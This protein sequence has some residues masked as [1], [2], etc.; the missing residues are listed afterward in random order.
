MKG[1]FFFVAVCLM[2]VLSCKKEEPVVLNPVPYIEI[3]SV[4]PLTLVQF[5]KNVRVT[6]SYDDQDGDLG[7]FHPDSLSLAATDSRLTVPDYYHISPLT[8]HGDSLHIR[9]T[10]ALDLRSPFLLGTGTSE[11]IHYTIKV[12]DRAG[13]WSNEI[14]TPNITITQ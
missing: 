3:I 7:F 6:F 1:N 11:I 14:Q 13:N 9:G 8:P 4:S 12:K 2:L 5:S 10:I